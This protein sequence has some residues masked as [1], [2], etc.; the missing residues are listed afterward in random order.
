MVFFA[1]RSLLL[2]ADVAVAARGGLDAAWFFNLAAVVLR[3]SVSGDALLYKQ[4]SGVAFTCPYC[5]ARTSLIGYQVLY[6]PGPCGLRIRRFP[7]ATAPP[8]QWV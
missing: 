8:T 6:P 1:T 3:V 7:R 5:W 4:D 2:V